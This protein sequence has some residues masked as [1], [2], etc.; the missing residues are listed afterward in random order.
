MI[1][2][3]IHQYPGPMRTGEVR[4]VIPI[5]ESVGVFH[6]LEFAV[7]TGFDGHLTLPLSVIERLELAPEGFGRAELADT[8]VRQFGLYDAVVSWHGQPRNVA[9]LHSE[10]QPSLL[11]MALLWGSRITID[12]RGGGEVVIEE[13]SGL[14]NLGSG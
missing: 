10:T 12:A 6:E 8:E 11:G 13:I 9:V 1:K 3:Y 4:V 2:G 14:D 7:D 5:E